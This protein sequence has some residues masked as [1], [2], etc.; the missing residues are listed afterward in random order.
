[1]P[2]IA[3]AILIPH[4]SLPYSV[5]FSCRELFLGALTNIIW[6]QHPKRFFPEPEINVTPLPMQRDFATLTFPENGYL[7]FHFPAIDGVS[8]GGEVDAELDDLLA[9]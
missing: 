4:L 2:A 3:A 5:G 6:S 9:G 7:L 8:L 1:M